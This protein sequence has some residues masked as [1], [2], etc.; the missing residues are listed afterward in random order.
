MK[1][2]ALRRNQGFACC[3]V[4]LGTIVLNRLLAGS[5]PGF[6][7][8]DHTSAAGLIAESTKKNNGNYTQ[9]DLD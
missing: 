8:L 9:T 7:D 3:R 4:A 1:F 6:L 2:H 5:P